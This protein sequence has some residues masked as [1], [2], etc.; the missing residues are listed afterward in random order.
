M[1]FSKPSR[2]RPPIDEKAVA[3]AIYMLLRY[4]AMQRVIL[5]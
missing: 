4:F 5:E 2:N 1:T 3:D